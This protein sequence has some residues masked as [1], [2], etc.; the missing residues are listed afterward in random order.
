MTERKTPWTWTGRDENPEWDGQTGFALVDANG[1]EILA[2]AEH[3]SSKMP[4]RE[5]QDL[6]AAAP[7][8][9]AERDKY[10][11]LLREMA[12]ALE[13]IVS[14]AKL[15]HDRF[16]KEVLCAPQAMYALAKYRETVK[17]TA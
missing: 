10:R 2:G 9:A 15:S 3:W 4:D 16:A 13:E 7:E 12:G 1:N 8:T 17:E 14:N 11:E 5:T 6:L